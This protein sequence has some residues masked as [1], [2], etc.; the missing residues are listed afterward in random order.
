MYKK[1]KAFYG[2]AKDTYAAAALVAAT[3]ESTNDTY[4]A[5]ATDAVLGLTQGSP[6]AAKAL[7]TAKTARDHGSPEVGGY[8][9]MRRGA[10]ASEWAS[11]WALNTASMAD[12][13]SNGTAGLKAWWAKAKELSVAVKAWHDY[14]AGATYPYNIA[15]D[16]AATWDAATYPPT[17]V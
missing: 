5:S 9:P 11:T 17:A 8:L 13:D 1:E 3:A 16:G 12:F 4:D 10:G 6:G 2:L 15:A 7:K 14:Y